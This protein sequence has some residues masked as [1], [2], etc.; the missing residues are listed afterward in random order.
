M[1]PRGRRVRRSTCWPRTRRWR[2]RPWARWPPR[3]APTALTPDGEGLR[4]GGR[5]GVRVAAM[6]VAHFIDDLVD[7]TLVI[8]PGD[9]ADIVVGEPRRDPR[10]GLP[11]RR[12]DRADRR[13]RAR[14]G[15]PQAAGGGAVPGDRDRRPAPIPPPRRCTTSAPSSPRRASARW[16]RRCR[17]FESAV[18]P[19]EIAGADRPRAPAADHA[20][21]VR[22]RAVERARASRRHIVLPEGDDDRVLQAADV[23]LRRDVVD[24]TILGDPDEHARPGRGARARPAGGARSWTRSSRRT[25]SASPR[26]TT[27]CESTRA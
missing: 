22:V 7:G 12:R 19:L 20:D 11:G 25:A 5:R 23:L 3:S 13:L 6:S 2:D 10:R 21:H 26:S 15:R 16:P 9:R 4:Q 18:D 17:S 8:V 14:R 1:R 24:L 27:T